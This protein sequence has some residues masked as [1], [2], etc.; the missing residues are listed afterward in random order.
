MKFYF[1]LILLAALTL[2]FSMANALATDSVESVNQRTYSIRL[3][4][5]LH[6]YG[7]FSY[8]GRIV[9]GNPAFDLQ[10]IYER[11]EWGFTL[12]KAVDLYSLHS[13][14]NFTMAMVYKN[15]A[16]GKRLKVTP[17][18]G[19]LL[20]QMHS[21]ADPGSDAGAIVITSYK[22]T[23][24]ITADHTLILA[25]LLIEPE[26]MDNVNRL[27]LLYSRKHLD[28]T[29]L[30]WHN[31]SVIDKAAYGS[32]GASVF[33]SRIVVSN[34]LDLGAGITGVMTPYTSSGEQVKN[35]LLLTITASVH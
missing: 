22:L 16:F 23:K 18:V 19:F 2:N 25:N 13:A 14:N 29:L 35:G 31:N 3:T 7:Y 34:S 20:E 28:L 8:G 5:R 17:Y 24:T 1:T 9:N 11:K 30:T 32:I 4:S 15:L 33:Y 21:I 6:S 12:F 27:R 10:F 26:L